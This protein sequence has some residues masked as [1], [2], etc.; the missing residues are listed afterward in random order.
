MRWNNM[1]LLYV[2]IGNFLLIYNILLFYQKITTQKLKWT[3][4]LISSFT[5]SSY[6]FFFHS[7]IPDY[8]RLIGAFLLILITIYMLEKRISISSFI[9][10]SLIVY[11]FRIIGF[12]FVSLLGLVF[13]FENN[14][15]LYTITLCSE[16]STYLFAHKKIKITSGMPILEDAEVR[17]ILFTLTAL[18]LIFHWGIMRLVGIENIIDSTPA[19]EIIAI[20]VIAFATIMISAI[21]FVIYIAKKHRKQLKLQQEN[22]KMEEEFAEVSADFKNIVSIHHQYKN[23]VPL[24]KDALL[25][26]SNE[27]MAT[28]GKDKSEHLQRMRNNIYT[29]HKLAGEV[30]NKIYSDDIEQTI[31]SL[32]LPD[33]WFP[34]SVYLKKAMQ[35]AIDQNI[36]IHLQNKSKNWQNIPLDSAKFIQ[37]IGALLDNAIK[38]TAR[39]NDVTKQIHIKFFDDGDAF[40]FE[41]SDDAK[42]FP[43]HILQN[44]GKRDNSTNGTGN[45]FVEI[46][47]LTKSVKASL[48]I[49]EQNISGMKVKDIQIIFDGLNSILIESDYRSKELRKAL[50]N[51]ILEVW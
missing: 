19:N 16:L 18:F 23:D 15:W 48:V 11:F 2:V 13:S 45:G 6:S 43:V 38:E 22:K 24:I 46:I 3:T 51:S 7:I 33:D 4:W 1:N 39:T 50:K 44:L 32:G 25:S 12:L 21:Y 20:L 36:T 9:A 28:F 27:W 35:E 30:E 49:K 37:L 31:G 10:S 26:I 17:E 29:L 5:F 14:M 40:S 47:N 42:E 41:I 8:F 34:L